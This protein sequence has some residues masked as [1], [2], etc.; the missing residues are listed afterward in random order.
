MSYAVL[1]RFAALILRL[2]WLILAVMI[3]T[4]WLPDFNR[5]WALLLA[6]PILAARLICYRRL[7]QHTPLDYCFIALIAV[8]VV[9]YFAAPFKQ[10]NV[11]LFS[12]FGETRPP[13][14]LIVIGRPLFGIFLATTFIDRAAR[15]GELR[16]LLW[17]TTALALLVGI[18]ALFSQHYIGKSAALMFIIR[19]L[20]EISGF[21]GA[22]GGFNVNEIA[23]A[24]AW[25][26]PFMAGVALLA[27]RRWKQE[28]KRPQ[29]LFALSSSAAFILLWTALFLGQSRFALLGVLPMLAV[30]AWLLIPKLAWRSLALSVVLFFAVIQVLIFTGS[31][32]PKDE[33][34][35]QRDED[36]VSSRLLIWSS[37]LDIAADYPLTGAGMNNFRWRPVRELYPVIGYEGNKILPHAHNEWLQITSD[38]GIFGLAAYIALQVTTLALLVLVWRGGGWRQRGLALATA[39]GMIAHFVYGM[40]DA[41]T[42]WDRFAFGFWW[43]VGLAGAQYVVLQQRRAE[44]SS[45]I[46]SETTNTSGV[47]QRITI[48]LS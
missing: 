16:W 39:C 3:A 34:L 23:G 25:L 41:I 38:L 22:E 47:S 28:R 36:S 8:C 14:N 43:F 11:E 26:T 31:L 15:Q 46:R 17:V 6:I 48:E 45:A 2:E 35:Q 44:K 27:W 20:P 37:A 13:Y 1:K 18:L 30:L 32:I 7:W 12:P 10:G 42:L 5:V 33:T 9:N 4:F 21:P 40:G 29:L 24:M 19:V